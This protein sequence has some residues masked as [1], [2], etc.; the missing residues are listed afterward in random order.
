[1]PDLMAT[2]PNFFGV[3]GAPKWEIDVWSNFQTSLQKQ[4]Q[5]V[6]DANKSRKYDFQYFDPAK[7]ECAVSL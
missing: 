2:F 6:R 5:N 4:S 7:M 3:D 1:M